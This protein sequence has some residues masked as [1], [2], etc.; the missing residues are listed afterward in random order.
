VKDDDASLELFGLLHNDKLGC[1]ERRKER[2]EEN[3]N[4][5]KRE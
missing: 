5:R 4:E 2:P 1:R 3:E